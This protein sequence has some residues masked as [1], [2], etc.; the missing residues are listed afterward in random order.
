MISESLLPTVPSW[1]GA[2]GEHIYGNMG[3]SETILG[4]VL[5]ERRKDIILATKFSGPMATS[6]TRK[7]ASRRYILMAVEGQCLHLSG[8][9]D[10][11]SGRRLREVWNEI[12][13]ELDQLCVEWK[14]RLL[15]QI[16]EE[17]VVTL[18]MIQDVLRRKHRGTISLV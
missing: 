17:P 9:F 1:G 14:K 10:G 5:G 2:I 12:S 8:N 15:W 11:R 18:E 7:E 3:G 16:E 13:K 6:K 4:Q